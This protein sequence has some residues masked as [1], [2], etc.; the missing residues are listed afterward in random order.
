MVGRFAAIGGA[1]GKNKAFKQ[2][3]FLVAH[4]VSG[5]DGLHSRYQLEARL[6]HRVKS[7]LSTQHSLMRVYEAMGDAAE[8]ASQHRKP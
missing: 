7:L 2:R 6:S 4:K 8:M 5:Q 3:P 1:D